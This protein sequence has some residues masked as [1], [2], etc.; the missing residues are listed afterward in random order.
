MK[1]L[2]RMNVNSKKRPKSS[3]RR[4]N[5]LVRDAQRC[6]FISAYINA[7]ALPYTWQQQ[8]GDVDIS[9]PVPKGSR[10]RD[11]KI[12]I[13]KSKLS[14]GLKGQEPIMEGELCKD[15]KVDDSTWTLGLASL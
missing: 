13:S 9:I 12:A 3:A 6:E 7:A 11:L 15:I 8:L 14:V 5:R 4:T 10:A 2:A 1:V